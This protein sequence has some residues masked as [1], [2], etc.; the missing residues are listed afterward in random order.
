M[1]YYSVKE[2]AA[3]E[4]CGPDPSADNSNTIPIESS[5]P[6]P[7]TRRS[8]TTKKDLLAA[9]TEI[10]RQQTE[11]ISNLERETKEIRQNQQAIIDHNVKLIDEV[12]ELKARVEDLAAAAVAGASIPA[13]PSATSGTPSNQQHTMAG[14]QF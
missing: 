3:L 13:G 11:T 8:T 6:D 2:G 10:I 4:D 1:E 9:L 5:Q 7:R 14:T 12:A